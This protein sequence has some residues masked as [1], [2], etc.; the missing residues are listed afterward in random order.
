MAVFQLEVTDFHWITE[1]PDDP[2]DLCLHGKVTARIGEEVLEDWGTVSAS[3]LYLLRS[4]TENHVT[5]KENQMIPCCGHFMIANEDLSAVEIIGCPNGTD[6][7]T[8][9]TE[10]GVRITTQSG[11]V[12]D[13]PM[14]QYREQVIAF[15]DRVEAYYKA[16]GPKKPSDDF[17]K[18]GYRAF[19]NEWHRHRYE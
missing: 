8:E 12:T 16:C 7:A 19:W 1:K 18:R 10:V 9:H 4:L 11:A 2:E 3:A 13:V 14:A 5:G 15:A 17:Q 6:W